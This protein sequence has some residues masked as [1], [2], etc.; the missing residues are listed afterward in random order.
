M[1]ESHSCACLCNV[2]AIR[3]ACLGSCLK[4]IES[5]GSSEWETSCAISAR[6]L[7]LNVPVLLITI[8]IIFM[9]ALIVPCVWSASLC[10]SYIMWMCSMMS[11]MLPSVEYLHS[12]SWSCL[13]PLYV[14]S[15]V[16]L[17]SG[18]SI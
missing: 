6:V 8:G 4:V 11:S 17:P 13:L 2:M 12:I 18:V 16:S 5:G 14:W 3:L 7:K 15:I 1:C 9:S 10:G